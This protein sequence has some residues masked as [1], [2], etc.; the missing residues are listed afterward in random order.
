MIFLGSPGAHASQ[1][2]RSL[3]Q[4]IHL[5]VNPLQGGQEQGPAGEALGVPD[6]G[7]HQIQTISDPGK[8]RN[9]GRHHDGCHILHLELIFVHMDPHALHH[10][11]QSLG[12][13]ISPG[14]V[15]GA[16]QAHNEAIARQLVGSD[17][18]HRGQILDPCGPGRPGSQDKSC[19]ESCPH[20]KKGN[21]L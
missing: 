14:L 5:A 2:N 21:P 1:G 17:T 10:V 12:G 20:Q 19:H 6:G 9:V 3:G 7:C 16:C 15:S 13:E 8:R 18:L 4:G 11:G